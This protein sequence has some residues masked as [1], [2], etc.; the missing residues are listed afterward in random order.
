MVQPFHVW[1]YFSPLVQT[2]E[3]C[4]EATYFASLNTRITRQVG[5]LTALVQIGSRGKE[6]SSHGCSHT[7]LLAALSM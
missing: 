2:E 7:R 4:S 1:C 5:A 6:K 3:A